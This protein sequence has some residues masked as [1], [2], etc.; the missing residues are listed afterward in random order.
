MKVE[1]L[2]VEKGIWF[3]V[4]DGVR[5]D[6]DSIKKLTF[7]VPIPA[8]PPIA[9]NIPDQNL[10]PRPPVAVAP[11][12]PP[13]MPYNGAEM[14]RKARARPAPVMPQ[15]QGMTW[16]HK[17][18]KT[19]ADLWIHRTI[20]PAPTRAPVPKGAN[21]LATLNHKEVVCSFAMTNPMSHIFTGGKGAVKIWDVSQAREGVGVPQ[22]GTIDCLE[23]YI[24]ATK[25]TNDGQRL[26]V[27]G[28]VGYMVICDVASPAPRVIG[29]IDTPNLLTY[30]LA[31]S[32]DS[33]YLFSC[34]S[35]GTIN[36]WDIHQR[37]LVRSLGHHN[38]TA[39][40]CALTTD[41]QR[42]ISGSLD[43]TVRVWDIIAGKEVL[44][45][46][47]PSRFIRWRIVLLDKSLEIRRMSEM[48]DN[49]RELTGVHQD[50]V[51]S[52]KYSP[53]GNWLASAGKDKKLVCWRTSDFSSIFEMSE[54][55]SILC[56]EISNCGD[57]MAT[58]TGDAIAN[59]YSMIY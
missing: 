34:H 5:Q 38:A 55:S 16:S 28:E 18:D 30:A 11:A 53:N 50:C 21:L 39:T 12:P 23:S 49:R 36:M 26:I 33:K 40:C 31:V 7:I 20:P 29:R 54:A 44:E 52:V 51:L 47:C 13:P 19:R 46:E 27:S 3:S 43:K 10:P 2:T 24:R 6:M 15:Q 35:E 25:M 42:V 56:T 48:V 4:Q 8:Q 41:G 22:V 37:R 17:K 58:G 45:L 9:P 59:L 1:Q 14:E 57:Y 32:N